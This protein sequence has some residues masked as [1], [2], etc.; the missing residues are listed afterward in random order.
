M[1]TEDPRPIRLKDYRPPDWLIET[2]ELDVSLDPTATT[3]R[4]KLRLKPNGAATPAPLVL[5][6][7]ELKLRSLAIDGKPLPSEA[8]VATPDRLTIAQPPN[9]AFT[10]E[11]ETTID[12]AANTQLMGLYRA[13]STY[14]T[15]CEA[16]G[17]RRITYFLD[18]PDVMAVYTTRIEADKSEA[19]VLL[20]NGNLV[21]KGDIP[22]GNRHFAVWHDPFKKPCYLFALVGGALA[23]VADSFRTMSGREVAL[24][25][26]VEPGQEQ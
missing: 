25:I 6:G 26:F 22:G 3:V 11:V 19:A 21:A 12:P 14:C 8:F 15:Q 1:R 10:L 17:F 24:H 18:R 23:C 2:V 9:Q 13:G 5:D 16:E 7:E 4:S 20:S